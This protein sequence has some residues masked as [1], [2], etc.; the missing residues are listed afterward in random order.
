MPSAVAYAR[1]AERT[2]CDK[3]W[4]ELREG[5]SLCSEHREQLNIALLFGY[6]LLGAGWLL[7]CWQSAIRPDDPGVKFYKAAKHPEWKL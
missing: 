2:D 5:G 6:G 7:P 4:R 1:L 3:C